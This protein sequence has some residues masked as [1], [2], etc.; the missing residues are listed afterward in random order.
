MVLV[1]R[2]SG[3]SVKGVKTSDAEKDSS[4]VPGLLT[5]TSTVSTSGTVTPR[6]DSEAGGDDNIP[7][8]RRGGSLRTKTPTC[9]NYYHETLLSALIFI[10]SM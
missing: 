6:T 7:A 10:L 9:K 2:T 4:S 3:D 1:S 8:W 5:P